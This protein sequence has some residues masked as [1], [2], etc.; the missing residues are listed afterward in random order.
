MQNS[1]PNNCFARFVIY[2]FV[3]LLMQQSLCRPANKIEAKAIIE[4]VTA[5][6]FRRERSEILSQQWKK[7]TETITQELNLAAQRVDAFKS[8]MLSKVARGELSSTEAE[9]QTT[10]C[11]MRE[12][13]PNHAEELANQKWQRLHL[14][15][16][17][18]VRET[19]RQAVRE[20]YLMAYPGDSFNSAEW[21]EPKNAADVQH[22]VEQS[23]KARKAEEDAMAAKL[24]QLREQ[25]T[26]FREAK[27][28]QYSDEMQ[29][30]YCRR[31]SIFVFGVFAT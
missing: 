19:Q 14:A 30:F 16:V 11:E 13:D 15:E 24:T 1:F 23:E 2:M 28:K 5:P 31:Q 12:L 7:V 29:V 4:R 3:F 26:E 25:E 17:E 10:S 22:A 27:Q 18:S 6:R 8:D 21:A 9:R 20:Y